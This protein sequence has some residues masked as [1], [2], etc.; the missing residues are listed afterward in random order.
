MDSNYL[1][2]IFSAAD[3]AW[4]QTKSARA[5]ARTK[6]ADYQKKEAEYMNAVQAA[7]DFF[8][9]GSN[10]RVLD[11]E[12]YAPYMD[13]LGIGENDRGLGSMYKAYGAGREVPLHYSDVE[14]FINIIKNPEQMDVEGL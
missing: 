4:Q 7:R 14:D 1:N 12:T 10:V 9:K 2:K 5:K 13:Y 6:M 11:D 3:K 8:G